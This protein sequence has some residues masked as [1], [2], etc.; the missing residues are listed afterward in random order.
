MMRLRIL[1]SALTLLVALACAYAV[2]AA[3]P[4]SKK[5]LAIDDDTKWRSITA[6][7]ISLRFNGRKGVLLAYRHEGH[8][9]R[10]IANRRDLTIRLFQFFDHYLQE[11]PA[12]TWMTEG[13]PYLKKDGR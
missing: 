7:E 6:Q 11:A 13:V 1:P 12:P 5:P 10:G 9:L 2:P 4:A 8:G 3:Q